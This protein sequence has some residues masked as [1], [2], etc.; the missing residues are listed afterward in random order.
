MTK[1]NS[2]P[3]P[4]SKV[5]KASATSTPYQRRRGGGSELAKTVK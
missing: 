4:Q 3:I 5:I 2:K 1:K